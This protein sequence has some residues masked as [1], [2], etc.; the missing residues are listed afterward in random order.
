MTGLDEVDKQENDKVG[1]RGT[2]LIQ[3]FGRISIRT[4]GE[5]RY[6]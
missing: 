5:T 4:T 2:Y 3:A 1:R 6:L